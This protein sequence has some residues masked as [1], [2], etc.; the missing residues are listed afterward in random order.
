LEGST[1][2]RKRRAVKGKK[3]TEEI[4]SNGRVW[5]KTDRGYSTFS[6]GLFENNF[7]SP[8]TS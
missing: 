3:T 6:L 4:E 2:T 5:K 7:R 8:L 1:P